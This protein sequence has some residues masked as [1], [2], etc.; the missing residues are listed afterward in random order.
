MWCNLPSLHWSKVPFCIAQLWFWKDVA[1][2]TYHQSVNGD[3]KIPSK[4]HQIHHSARAELHS[5]LYGFVWG[6][7]GLTAAL[8]QMLALW[9]LV[10]TPKERRSSVGLSGKSWYLNLALYLW[11]TTGIERLAWV[12]WELA[13]LEI[14][15][16]VAVH[17]PGRTLG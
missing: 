16:D 7:R 4:D 13:A 14:C 11:S 6:G 12:L 8:L 17:R 15:P 2:L 10:V 1:V 3:G 9:C 5:S